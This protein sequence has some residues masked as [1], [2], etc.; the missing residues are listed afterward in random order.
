MPIKKTSRFEKLKSKIKINV[1]NAEIK[2][3]K[4]DIGGLKFRIRKKHAGL[5][6]ISPLSKEGIK[7]ERKFLKIRQNDLKILNRRLKRLKRLKRL[8]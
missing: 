3:A 7:R 6:S 8:R 2:D 1:T 4:T 5:L